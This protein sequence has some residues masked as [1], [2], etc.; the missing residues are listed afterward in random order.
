MSSGNTNSELNWRVEEWFPNLGGQPLE[1]LHK[2]FETLVKFNKTL[3]LV[4]VK[5]IAFA[6]SV[7]FADSIL[8]SQIVNEKINKDEYLYDIGSGNGFP[9]LVYSILYPEQKVLLVDS[10]ER[11]CEFLKYVIS[12]C[13]LSNVAVLNKK[14]ETLGAESIKQAICRG[15]AP[16]PFALLQLRKCSALGAQIYHLKSEE[17]S[18]EVSQI[19]TQLCSIWQPGLVGEYRLPIGDAKMFVVNTEKIS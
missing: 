10:D 3:N 8:A 1:L 12:T 15:Y 17:W 9:G 7:H 13:K 18:L 6:D 5:T 11:K 14:V 4:S 2:Y 19:P 16:L